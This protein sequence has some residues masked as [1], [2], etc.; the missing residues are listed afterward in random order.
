MDGFTS[1]RFLDKLVHN[2]YEKREFFNTTKLIDSLL[3]TAEENGGEHSIS[4]VILMSMW[5]MM[6]VMIWRIQNADELNDD[7]RDIQPLSAAI[8][9]YLHACDA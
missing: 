7:L 9:T 3:S 8:V 2:I 1:N 6:C 5:F 4:A